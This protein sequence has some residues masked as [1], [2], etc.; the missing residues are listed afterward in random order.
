[1]NNQGYNTDKIFIIDLE[2]TCWDDKEKGF[3][4]KNSEIIQIG[5]VLV[6]L[7]LNKILQ[8]ESFYVKPKV[9]DISD[10]CT[11]LTGIKKEDLENSPGLKT[12]LKKVRKSFGNFHISNNLWGSWGYYDLKQLEKETLNKGINKETFSAYNYIDLSKMFAIQNQLNKRPSVKKALEIKGLRFEGLQHDAL[13]DA[14][15]TARL[16]LR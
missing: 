12:V 5:I 7:K 16:F 13:N 8:K 15:N 1:M 10:Y 4:Q 14:Y 11:K 9:M 2:A 3:Q 6:D